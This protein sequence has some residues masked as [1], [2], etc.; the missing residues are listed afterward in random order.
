MNTIL[1]T[2]YD[3]KDNQIGESFNADFTKYMDANRDNGFDWMLAITDFWNGRSYKTV[4]MPYGN[5][6]LTLI[7]TGETL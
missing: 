1:V 7:M 5:V 6:E 2:H 3:S 4:N